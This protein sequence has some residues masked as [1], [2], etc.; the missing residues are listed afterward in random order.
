MA[1]TPHY[2]RCIKPNESKRALEFESDRVLHQV[3][4]LGLKENIRVRRAGYAYRRPFDKFLWRYAILSTETWPLR[5]FRGD[6]RKGCEII[7]RSSGISRDQFQLGKSKIFIKNPESLFLLEEA[8]ERKYDSYARVLQKAFKKFVA[9]KHHMKMKEQASDLFFGKKERRRFSLN[10]NFVG[11]YI[12]IENNPNLQLI[13][14]KRQK[15]DFA[16]KVTKY[17]RRFKTTKLDLILT[18]KNLTMVGRMIEK[19]GPNKGKMIEE[20]KRELPLE[21]ITS[22][23]LSPF[24][25]DFFVLNVQG[26]Y[27]SL[28]ETPLKTELMMM[29][30]KRYK[31]KTGRELDLIFGRSFIITLKKEKYGFGNPGTREIKFLNGNPDASGGAAQLKVEGKTLVVTVAPGLPNNTS[32]KS[33]LTFHNNV[34]FISGPKYRPTEETPRNNYRQPQRTAPG[35]QQNSQSQVFTPPATTNQGPPR[36]QNGFDPR[37]VLNHKVHGSNAVHP[38]APATA[39]RPAP[40]PK[41]KIQKPQVK[42]LYDYDARD[43]DELTFKEGQFIELISE[44]PSGWWQGKI[45]TKTG[46][47]PS[48]YV[49]KI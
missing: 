48:N 11:D 5:N 34:I 14:G 19:K 38:A 18:S 29:L 20:V 46:L 33:S 25:D 1:C 31:E 22:I 4:Y 41:P 13:A 17:D 16:A 28:L 44:D 6:A 27:T 7:C 10:R 8:R 3:K 32:K 42:A 26:E 15:I 45:G 40:K 2:V 23:G 43:V 36:Q 12:G 35:Y 37:Q 24:Q 9:K 30:T 49:E 21:R 47:F 39:P